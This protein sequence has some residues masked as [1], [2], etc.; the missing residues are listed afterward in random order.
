MNAFE[1]EPAR[2][3]A[4]RFPAVARLGS[5]R[6]RP[7]VPVVRQMEAADCGAAC[8]S[9]VL[10]L[11]GQHRT[12]DEVRD[13][14]GSGRNGVS[15]L[16]I[17]QVARGYG[18][19]G[20]GIKLE[21][22]D[23]LALVPRGTVLHWEFNHFV[24]YESSDARGV[25][26]IDPAHGHRT[27]TWSE[28]GRAFT[29]VALLLE[30]AESFVRRRTPRSTLGRHLRSVFAH[31]ELWASSLWMSLM[32][33][34][35]ALGLPFATTVLVDRIIPHRDLELL[36]LLAAGLVAMVGFKFVC[37]L[38]RANLL[39]QLR[40]LLDAKLTIG[41][42]DRLVD[43]PFSFFQKRS[44]GDLLMR[45][46][47]NATVRE[48]ISSSA[49]S[50]L[51][52]G[53]LAVLYLL[54]I[55]VSSPLMAMVVL[56]IAL[57]QL[58]VYVATRRRQ[59][60]LVSE[61]LATQ[62]K[63]SGY[64]VEMLTRIET[65]KSMGAEFRAVDRWSNLFVDSL[66]VSL[67]RG[68]LDAFIASILGALEMAAPLI[69]LGTG[70]HLVFSG[71]LSLGSML[72]IC[73]LAAG[74]LTPLGAL[75]G[76]A[77]QLQTLDSYLERIDDVMQ[78]PP[79][80]PAGSKRPAPR[81]SG[82]I[83]SQGLTFGYSSSEPA[84]VQD[85]SFEALPGQFVAIVGASGAGKS[86]LAK[87]LLGLHRPAS[88]SVL[89]DGHDLE[90]LD[91]R[92]VRGQ[93]GVVTQGDSLFG[94]SIRENIALARPECDLKEVVEAAK[95]ASIHDEIMAL[96]MGYDTVLADG[97]STLSGGQQQRLA[98]ARA[99]VGKPTLVLL[100]EATSN[101]DRRT[102]AAVQRALTSL[103][104]TRIVIA[105]RLSTVVAADKIIVLDHGRVVESGTHR[106]LLRFE[107]VYRAL[108]EREER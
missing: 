83:Q 23:E 92:S 35:L 91:L 24:V 14:M 78:T 44:A 70:A 30:P 26:I 73:A 79:E 4:R 61:S 99:L 88:G 64:E 39:L 32:V 90:T 13:T 34:V 1:T 98:L 16:G 72:G 71:E 65:L 67:R 95:L 43:L 69:V 58:S 63:T 46:G 103:R 94:A 102:E 3:W 50:A 66:N 60:E 38:L 19:R 10:A 76:V 77:L 49:M 45:L 31:R 27:V 104:C 9:M 68:R 25:T 17:V 28:V 5:I 59:K 52:D 93:L 97:G 82:R 74:F 86:T 100:D 56:A 105:H 89:F 33:Q 22:R 55:F 2:G 106:E 12:L 18:L 96:P 108:Y 42:L 87:L 107:G 75:V 51:L 41:F 20:R 8:L 6:P 11:H 37:A 36:F 101:M 85:V 62:A 29:G 84:A 53:S 54:L 48:I 47:S 15:A 81:L 40:T 80:Q 21:T 7:R 57:A